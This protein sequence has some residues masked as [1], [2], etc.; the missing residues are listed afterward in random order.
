MFVL[1]LIIQW[2]NQILFH[3]H[4]WFIYFLQIHATLYS[5]EIEYII[6]RYNVLSTEQDT[7]LRNQTHLKLESDK[8][9][10]A[11]QQFTKDQMNSNL[12]L[13]TEIARMN[14]Y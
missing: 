14:N 13:N 3:R 1:V 11:Y 7:L 2:L 10:K 4:F 8:L 12:G 5:Q 6:H 9:Q